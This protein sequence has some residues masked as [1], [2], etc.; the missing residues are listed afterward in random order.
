M[1]YRKIGNFFIIFC[2]NHIIAQIIG[3]VGR[4][5]IH[6]LL[7]TSNDMEL[8]SRLNLLFF[9]GSGIFRFG[10]NI[11]LLIGLYTLHSTQ[12]D[13]KFNNMKIALVGV[14]IANILSILYN[15][16]ISP[17]LFNKLGYSP[18]IFS[19]ISNIP[20]FI[21]EIPFIILTIQYVLW[22]NSIK[23][24]Y[25]NIVPTWNILIP[26]IEIGRLIL[27]PLIYY[28]LSLLTNQ[29]FFSVNYLFPIGMFVCWGVS[30]YILANTPSDQEPIL[31]AR[32]DLVISMNV[33]NS[34]ET[35]HRDENTGIY[36]SQCGTYQSGPKGAFC[37]SCGHRL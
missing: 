16:I 26:I 28:L 15:Y 14:M 30:A 4:R 7:M 27:A 33:D 32:D 12:S 24:S 1:N 19:L 23:R 35:F 34:S 8:F 25:P 31:N 17:V 29:F 21:F 22:G 36:C 5:T 18:V 6:N 9:I 3:M 13:S 2:F 11:T 37:K 10:G 20:Y